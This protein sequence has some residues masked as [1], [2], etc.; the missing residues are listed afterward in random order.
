MRMRR[1]LLCMYKNM[2]ETQTTCY[3]KGSPDLGP[4]LVMVFRPEKE[5]LGTDFEDVAI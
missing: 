1:P 2:T 5:A 3:A 4:F